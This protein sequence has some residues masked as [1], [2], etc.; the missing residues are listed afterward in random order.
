MKKLTAFLIAV[1]MCTGFSSCGS[2]E[3]SSQDDTSANSS[4]S[5]ESTTETTAVS[6]ECNHKWKDATCKSPKIC[7]VCNETYGETSD[8]STHKGKCEFCGEYILDEAFIPDFKDFTDCVG[9]S[10]IPSEF[11]ISSTSPTDAGFD[12]YV[13]IPDNE[14]IESCEN[15][16]WDISIGY[17]GTADFNIINGYIM[18]YVPSNQNELDE[19][20]SAILNEYEKKLGSPTADKW[21]DSTGSAE[22]RVSKAHNGVSVFI[23][24]TG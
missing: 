3:N 7:E 14:R 6:T 2:A 19:L 11:T 12:V 10:E 8:H 16:G 22:L 5:S 18:N 1:T 13:S 21:L 24:F 15:L 20:Y 9:L 4:S 23:K 17:T